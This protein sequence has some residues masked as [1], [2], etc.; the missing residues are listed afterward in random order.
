MSQ[1]SVHVEGLDKLVVK[2]AH[3]TDP[4]P[5]LLQEAGEF[6]RDR[7]KE[8]AK[9]HPVDKGTLAEGIRFELAGKGVN[10]QALIKPAYSI[11]GIA[12]VV[13]RGRFPG[14]PP[15]VDRFKRWALLHRYITPVPYLAEGEAWKLTRYIAHHGTKG[16]RMFARAADETDKKLPALVADT[17][18]R[19]E[20]EWR[21]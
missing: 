1:V 5:H 6:A 9:P 17:T 16:V 21:K 20:K 12:E 19:I 4:I 11:W 10:L 18:A 3:V 2:L 15:T 14:R 7:V 8:Y 13:E